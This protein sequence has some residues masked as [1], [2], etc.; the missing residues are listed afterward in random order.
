MTDTEP[1]LAQLIDRLTRDHLLE[2]SNDDGDLIAIRRPP[3][4]RELANAR[5]ASLGIGRGSA[6]QPHQRVSLNLE[7]SELLTAIENRIRAWATR[8]GIRPL[9]SWPPAEQV[10]AAWHTSADPVTISPAQ[11]R[12]I[13]D[14][15]QQIEDLIDPPHRYTLTA[16][17]PHC[18]T[19]YVNSPDSHGRALQ[20]IER[21]PAE[22][23]VVT[24]RGCGTAW[25]GI[26]G[27]RTLATLLAGEPVTT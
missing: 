1:D 2:I 25:H 22:N 12:R 10:L 27:A 13:A 24:C 19:G 6:Q 18:G 14:W 5:T 16:P 26:D 7:A 23:S 9:G 15:V 17:C 4:L 21:H 11:A 8:D 20:V 3:L